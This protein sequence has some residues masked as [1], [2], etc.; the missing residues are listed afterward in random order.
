MT[1]ITVHLAVRRAATTALVLALALSLT[2]AVPNPVGASPVFRD[3]V[4]TT[5]PNPGITITGGGWGH[6]VGMSQYGAYAMAQAGHNATQILRHYY[7]GVTVAPDTMPNRLRVGLHR[8]M[9][10]SD[11]D[12]LTGRVPWA[13]CSEGSCTRVAVQPKGSTWRVRLLAD[14]DY[15][16]VADGVR[17]WKGGQGTRLVANF[18]PK[19]KSDGTVVRAFNPN[20]SRRQY[21]WGRLEYSVNSPTNRTMYMVLDIPTIELY[22]RG[23]GEVPNSWGVKGPAA[24]AA[25]AITGRTYAL[26]M[27]RAFNGNR[28][29]CRC[30]LL[31]TPA[32]QAYTGYEKETA[33]YGNYWVAAVDDT[34][35]QVASHNGTLISTYYSSSHGGRSENSEDSWA[36][37]ASLP[38]LRSVD[39]KWSLSP[40][41][42]NP[43]STWSTTVGNAA[44]AKFVGQGVSQVRAVSISGR[45]DGGSPKV[46]NVAGVDSSGNPVTVTRTG[47]KGIVGIDLRSAFS[48]SGRVNLSTL[49]SQQVRTLTF[50]PFDDDDG[51]VHEYSIIYANA[52]GIMPGASA[53]KFNPSGVVTRKAMAAFLYRTFDLPK[54]TKDHFDDDNGLPEE[55]AINAVAEAGIANGVAPRQFAPGRRLNRMQMATFFYAALGLSPVATDHFDDDN[56]LVHETSI[57]AIAEKGIVGG[58]ATRKFCPKQRIR[59]AQMAT[60]LYQTV[61][62]YR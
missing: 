48:F 22:L 1:R 24:L 35:A 37:S 10:A 16:L 36:Y 47:K 15:A 4:L 53:T 49:P 54:P 38:Y 25:Q 12:A 13:T 59:R 33:Q 44:F 52:A 21:K 57:N 5:K 39:D 3:K 23:L 29:D 56:G 45:T 46:L 58:C 34:A 6:S 20:G 50:G 41:S 18:N 61:E 8:A 17:Q 62:A 60:F 28:G 14:G 7:Q 51:N 11:V 9:E 27:H 19:A 26:G 2:A 30:S 55:E 43:L 40:T 32:N 42:G 31:A